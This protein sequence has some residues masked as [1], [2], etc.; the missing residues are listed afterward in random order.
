M[1]MKCVIFAR[2]T[3]ELC[4]L[5]YIIKP[6]MLGLCPCD[7]EINAN[8]VTRNGK[9]KTFILELEL[10]PGNTN[11]LRQSFSFC[12]PNSATKARNKLIPLGIENEGTKS[13]NQKLWLDVIIRWS[14]QNLF[15]LVSTWRPRDSFFPSPAWTHLY[16]WSI[17]LDLFA[18]IERIRTRTNS[19]AVA[20]ATSHYANWW[21]VDVFTQGWWRL[22]PTGWEVIYWSQ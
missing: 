21:L 1:E 14:N 8:A 20:N 13:H 18:S 9:M 10:Q 3:V 22:A 4:S 19:A 6:P 2:L 11:L 17:T 12:F 7:V 15:S 5:F 16:P